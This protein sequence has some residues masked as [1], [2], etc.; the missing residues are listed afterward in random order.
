MSKQPKPPGAAP[1]QVM[2]T[3]FRLDPTR[4]LTD[5]RWMSPTTSHA[6][7]IIT[8]LALEHEA[9]LPEDHRRLAK[10]AGMAPSTFKKALSELIE[11][12]IVWRANGD[13]L[14]T[15]YVA[16]EIEF[17]EQKRGK[18]KKAA[19]ARWGKNDEKTRGGGYGRNAGGNADAMPYTDDTPPVGRDGKRA[20]AREPSSPSSASQNSA[21]P[22][23]PGG[24]R[25]RAFEEIS[26]SGETIEVPGLGP[27]I[28]CEVEDRTILVRTVN[29]GASYDAEYL[30]DGSFG[31]I[32]PSSFG[33][34]DLDDEVPF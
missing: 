17:R 3:W 18:S 24:S 4:W 8:M 15:D 28:I 2:M 6:Y 25:R 27:C 7:T 5:V 21:P 20:I 31:R 1:T 33:S 26:D 11:D 10:Y 34:G 13:G 22:R 16:Q 19:G 12:G 23:S 32:T 30:A 9:P 14:M 29:D